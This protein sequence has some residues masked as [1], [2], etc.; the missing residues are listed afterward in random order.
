[1]DVAIQMCDRGEELRESRIFLEICAI[2]GRFFPMCFH[3]LKSKHLN[4]LVTVDEMKPKKLPIVIVS[5]SLFTSSA[6]AI[7][8]QTFFKTGLCFTDNLTWRAITLSQYITS[9]VPLVYS[10]YHYSDIHAIFCKIHETTS[11]ADC[12][13]CVLSLFGYITLRLVYPSPRVVIQTPIAS[14][15]LQVAVLYVK[16]HEIFIVSTCNYLT[17]LFFKC[18]HLDLRDRP[19]DLI[20]DLPEVVLSRELYFYKQFH[21]NI[22]EMA[23]SINKLS[24]LPIMLLIYNAFSE[25]AYSMYCL[26]VYLARE[27]APVLLIRKNLFPLYCCTKTTIWELGERVAYLIVCF[28]S[29][30]NKSGR[31]DF[32]LLQRSYINR[33][34]HECMPQVLYSGNS[35]IFIDRAQF[36]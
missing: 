26:F 3:L 1:M 29:E 33:D 34:P 8:Q 21:F 31:S 9:A 30:I 14:S 7:V 25:T 18:I 4:E 15:I 5:L 16:L 24:G 23:T 13:V 6:Y 17:R 36:S 11:M 19:T 2:Y 10:A 20:L 27:D 12:V 28:S 32:Q 35:R 22:W